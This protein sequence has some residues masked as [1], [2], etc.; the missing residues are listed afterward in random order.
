ME[1]DRISLE[2]GSLR[3]SLRV[4]ERVIGPLR[5]ELEPFFVLHPGSPGDAAL[6]EVNLLERPAPPAWLVAP[7][8]EHVSVDTSLYKHLASDGVK[9]MVAGGYVIRI[10]STR[11]WV[12]F[13]A[14]T[15]RVDVYQ[16][17]RDLLVRDGVRTIKSLVTP[18]VER[19][20]GVQ[21]H[22]AA[23][24]LEDGRAVILLGDMW[25]GKTTLLL[26][27]LAGFRVRQLTCDTVV[28]LPRGEGISVHGW[29]SP[30]SVS[31]G[32]MSDHPELAA[33][34]PPDRRDVAY[35]S[36]WR[37]G[38]KAVLSSID[39][40]RLFGTTIAPTATEIADCLVVRFKPDEPTGLRT[41]EDQAEVASAL[42]AMYL[43]SRDPIYHD[44]HRYIQVTDAD[45]DKNIEAIARRLIESCPVT[46]MT[47][48][49][50]AESLMKRVPALGQAHKHLGRLLTSF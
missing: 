22:A 6:L 19:A 5:A 46:V 3:L 17:D 4:H 39:V 35:D 21:L 28:L 11:T 23:V 18:A 26:E 34:F 25:Q 43:G 42:Q 30:F 27:L 24:A 20:G 15:Q 36:L 41:T 16:P 7:D 31:H 47:W 45:I 12:F 10:E 14:S 1:Q 32:T 49:P 37:E 50:S 38:R 2:F 33:A 9:L 48:A 13:D 8:G 44:W 40:V 29:P